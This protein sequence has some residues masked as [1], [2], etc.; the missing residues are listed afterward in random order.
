MSAE[1][2][3]A[4]TNIKTSD[5]ESKNADIESSDSDVEVIETYKQSPP[6]KKVNDDQQV[7]PTP[8][9]PDKI[10]DKVGFSILTDE[11]INVTFTSYELFF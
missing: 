6:G 7:K 4:D 9:S 2:D 5:S 8:H 3:L 11:N 10:N 1:V